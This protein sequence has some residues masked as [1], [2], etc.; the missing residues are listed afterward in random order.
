[1]A[2]IRL[3]S[4]NKMQQTHIRLTFPEYL[5]VFNKEFFVL[6]LSRAWYKGS[7]EAHRGTIC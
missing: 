1:M 5:N 2:A 7:S 3:H 6:S 4:F